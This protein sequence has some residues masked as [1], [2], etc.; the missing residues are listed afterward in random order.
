[1]GKHTTWVSVKGPVGVCLLELG[2]IGWHMSDPFT[3]VSGEG[4]SYS[5]LERAPA[6]IQQDLMEAHHKSIGRRFASSSGF[7]DLHGVRVAPEVMQRV[8]RSKRL[9]PLEKGCLRCMLAGGMWAQQR[10]VL[11]DSTCKLCGVCVDTIH[12]RLYECSAVAMIRGEA[13]KSD[14]LREAIAAGPGDPLYTRGLF[15]HPA[16]RFPPPTEATESVLEV[17]GKSGWE[18]VSSAAELG[19]KGDVFT[20]GS[21][22]PHMLRGMVRAGWGAVMVDDCGSVMARAYGPVWLPLPQTAPSAEWA[23]YVLCGLPAPGR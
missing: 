7:L 9:T 22:R 10:L 12:H 20:D 3:S 21:F 13:A 4:L 11:V 2:M 6:F 15:A 5:L 1:M 19:L 14:F 18:P 23:A 17:H 16:D 8:L